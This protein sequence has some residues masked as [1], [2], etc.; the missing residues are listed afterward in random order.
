MN[1]LA[2]DDD[3]IILDLLVASLKSF[4]FS[5]VTTARS[6]EQAIEIISNCKNPFD[7]FLLDIQMPGMNGVELCRYIRN[8]Q[9]LKV[10]PILMIT[11]LS[12]RTHINQAFAAG[13]TD[14]VT[15]PFDALELSTRIRLAAQLVG[16]QKSLANQTFALQALE[17][18]FDDATKFDYVDAVKIEDVPGMIGFVELENYL[19]QLSRLNMFRTAAF[20]LKLIGFREVY[21]TCSATVSYRV[22][23]DVADAIAANLKHSEFILSY[24]GASEFIC[25][26]NRLNIL[27]S[28]ELEHAINNSLEEMGILGTSSSYLSVVVGPTVSNSLF[29]VDRPNMLIMKALEALE[30]QTGNWRDPDVNR[31]KTRL[32]KLNQSAN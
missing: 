1:I 8:Q 32:A 15:K 14:Y 26:N 5:E 18:Q 22:L 20:G 10:T 2:I 11:S 3:E 16:E 17:A 25:V 19:L 13:A 12:D 28:D 30:S 4:G 31:P 6:A 9:E 24:C 27:R 7:C 23:A 29:S 21:S